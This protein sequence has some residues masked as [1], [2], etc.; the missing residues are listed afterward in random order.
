[1]ERH[2]CQE[3]ATRKHWSESFPAKHI[4]IAGISE[5]R[6][7]GSDCQVVE[8]AVL[9]HSGGDQLANGVVLIV[10]SPFSKAL[11]GIFLE[12]PNLGAVTT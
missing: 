8:G 7:P 9:L 12:N 2:H 1:M 3:L 11:P 5:S 6:L 10:H 4:G